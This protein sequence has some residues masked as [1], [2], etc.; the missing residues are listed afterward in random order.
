M[1]DSSVISTT[2]EFLN[3]YGFTREKTTPLFITGAIVY[4]FISCR[5]KLFDKLF[6]KITNALIEIQ[7]LLRVAGYSIQQDV[8]REYG[9]SGS[10]IVLKSKYRPFIE[11]SELADQISEKLPQLLSW[12]KDQKPRTGIDAQDKISHF[13]ISGKIEDYLDLTDYKQDLYEKGK[14]ARDVMGIL[15]VYLFEVLIPKLNFRRK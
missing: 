6:R 1:I 3:F 14:T 5:L 12:L 10:P 13:V 8:G 2:I 9:K 15:A 11:K 4:W 7:T